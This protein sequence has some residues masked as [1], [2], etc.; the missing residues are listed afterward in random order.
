MVPGPIT[1]RE[2]TQVAHFRTLRDRIHEG[3][4]YTVLGDSNNRVTK[5][6]G[7]PSRVL[8]D[9]FDGMPT[10]TQKYRKKARKIPRLDT[11]PYGMAADIYNP[12]RIKY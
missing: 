1:A 4:L 10:Y 11:R 9:P 5:P 2:R 7:A 6:G 3:P 12:D 8:V